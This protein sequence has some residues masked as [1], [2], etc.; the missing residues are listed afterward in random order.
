MKQRLADYRAKVEDG[1]KRWRANVSLPYIEAYAS[2]FDGY[3]KAINDQKETDKQR[4]ELFVAGASLLTGSILMA[5][6][7][8]SSLRALAGRAALQ[9]ICNRNMEAT[10]N[11]FHAFS[12]NKAMMFALGKVLDEVK[13]RIGKQAEDVVSQYMQANSSVIAA[14]TP[15]VQH[16]QLE[17]MLTNHELCAK[18]IARLTEESSKSEAE[19]AATYASLLAAPIANPP[20]RS[21]NPVQLAPKLEL[22]FYMT[23]ILDSDTLIDWP[24]Q[25]VGGMGGMGMPYGVKERRIEI[26]PS[27]PNYPNPQIPRSSGMVIPAHQSIGIERLGSS[28]RKRVDEVCRQARGRPFYGSNSESGSSNDLGKRDELKAA[29][30]ILTDYAR[31]T[32]PQTM[33][34]QKL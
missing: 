8:T 32:R 27:S 6:V 11:A 5:A 13:S 10:F 20:V 2:A 15:L 9:I 1:A 34:D 17:R 31:D 24:A 25:A 3:Q 29:E 26:M 22:S 30:R 12:T 23:A 7:A 19:K 28:I 16:V 14:G 4:A 18:E 21:I 33:L